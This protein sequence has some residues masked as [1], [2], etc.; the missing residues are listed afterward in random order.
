MRWATRSFHST[1]RAW[2]SSSMSRQMTAAPYSR[3][4]LNDPVEAASPAASPSSRLAELRMAR[5]PSHCRPA[6]MT[7]GSV[8]SSTSGHAG[9]GGEARGDLVHVDGAVAADVVD[10]HVEDVGAFLDLVL[11]HLRRSVS[12]SAVEHRLAELLRA[13]G[14]G[15][16]ADD[17]ERGVLV[18]RHQRVDRRGARPRASG[19]RGAGV[20][21]AAARRP[22]P[23]GARAWCRSSRRRRSTPSSVTK[24]RVVARPA[25]RA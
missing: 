15:A 25:A 12:Q 23:R 13:V 6:S 17:Q 4:S 10:A 19:A 16:L 3:A 21:V 9:L 5:P 7:C 14:V 2:P 24:R 20:E 11:G 18:E 1:S 8:E 22:R